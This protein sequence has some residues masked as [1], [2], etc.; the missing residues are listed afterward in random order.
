M[1]F[2]K[3]ASIKFR[4]EPSSSLDPLYQ[5]SVSDVSSAEASC[6]L[7][8]VLPC[9]LLLPAC[10]SRNPVCS[11]SCL[12]RVADQTKASRAQQDTARTSA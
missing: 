6:Q 8:A 4:G 1:L 2:T 7:P 11:S 3:Q 12:A 5:Q 10:C 9:C